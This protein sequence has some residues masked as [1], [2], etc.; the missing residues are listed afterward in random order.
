MNKNINGQI[1]EL[2]KRQFFKIMQGDVDYYK[3]Y[4]IV[5]S[6]EQQYVKDEE[7]QSNTIYIV[8][9]FLPS[10]LLFG[11]YVQNITIDAVSEQNGIEV[12]KTLLNEY[13]SNYNL[14]ADEN[15]VNED[16]EIK[17]YTMKQTYT[18]PMVSSNFNEIFYGFRS[19]FS[20]NGTFVV[21]DRAN[22]FDLYYNGKKV[23]CLSNQWNYTGTPSTQP[24]FDNKNFTRSIVQYGTFSFNFNT[25]LLDD[26]LIN[27]CLQVAL[28]DVGSQPKGVNTD[29]TFT[30]QFKNGIKLENQVFK[31]V[32][33]QTQQ[34]IGEIPVI[35]I[36]FTN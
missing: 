15:R 28:K 33:V 17:V 6:N 35:T 3:N 10:S 20:M 16:G 13:A 4:N 29:F 8:V 25:F 27:K 22:T 5:L 21:S 18:T 36:T 26:E 32:G 9:K 34:N 14:K 23:E 24:Y 7:R 31:L 1:F 11:Q 30:I 19:L 2:I 12:C